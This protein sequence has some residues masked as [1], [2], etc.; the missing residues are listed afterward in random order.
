VYEEYQIE[1][2]ASFMALYVDPGR[3]K[4]NAPRDVV[5]ARYELCEDMAAMLTEAAKNMLFSLSIA[6]HDVLVKCHQGLLS[7]G[8]VVTVA[9]AVWVIRRLAELLDWEHP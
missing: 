2:P 7:E 8:A 9:E 4:P 5:A 3:Q 1:I 6:E